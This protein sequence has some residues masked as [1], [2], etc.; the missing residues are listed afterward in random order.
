MN[1][2]IYRLLFN[3]VKGVWVVVGEIA[4]TRQKTGRRPLQQGQTVSL[5]A[6]LSPLRCALLFA[7]GHLVLSAPLWAD[8][9]ADPNAPASQQA[10]ILNTANG[11]P[12]VNIQTPT[13]GGVSRNQY[14]QFDVDAQGAILNN[15]RTNTTTQLGGL[16]SANPYL[17]GGSATVILNE[18]NSTNPSLLNGHIEVAGSR[19]DIIFANPAGISCSGCGFIN[20]NQTVLTTG[21]VIFNGNTIDAY[22]VN[23]G[24]ISINGDGLD[25][26]DSNFTHLISRSVEVNAGI[27][28][29]DLQITTG[30]NQV[31]ASNNSVTELGSGSG[32]PNFAIDVSALG[33]MYANVIRLVGTEDGVGVRNAG[34]IGASVGEFTL[35]VDGRLE[36]T[37]IIVSA[38]NVTLSA[39]NDIDNI[40]GEIHS[41]SGISITAENVLN[42]NGAITALSD[43]A[44]NTDGDLINQSGSILSNGHVTI[45]GNVTTDAQ[46]INNAEGLIQSQ[47]TMTLNAATINNTSSGTTAG[48][49]AGQALTLSADQI[50]NSQGYIESAAAVT[51]VSTGEVNNAQGVIEAAGDIDIRGASVAND[52]GY[53]GAVGNIAL[54]TTGDID[55]RQGEVITNKALTANATNIDNRE[56]SLRAQEDITLDVGAG[57]LQNDEGFIESN[58]AVDIVAATIT[59]TLTR[60]S[61][62][63]VDDD[64]NPIY[65]SDVDGNFILDED[66]DEQLQYVLTKGIVGDT[67]TIAADTVDNRDGQIVADITQVTADVSIDNS[68]GLIKADAGLNEITTH[69]LTQSETSEISGVDTQISVS[70]TFTNRGL[71]NSSGETR[72]DTETLLNYGTG[73]I[74]GDHIIIDAETLKNHK[75]GN[76]SA[77]IA[78]RTE[79]DIGV[80]TL[81]NRDGSTIYS[82]GDIDIGGD[83]DSDG[84]AE[85]TANSI[86]NASATI[87]ALKNLSIDADTLDN[88]DL[89]FEKESIRQPN[90]VVDSLTWREIW[91]EEKIRT[92]PS[93]LISGGDSTFTVDTL[94]SINSE[95]T[96]GGDLTHIGSTPNNKGTDGER[97]VTERHAGYSYQSCRRTWYGKKKCS[98]VVVT[99][100]Y[101]RTTS[102]TFTLLAP[103]FEGNNDKTNG[104]DIDDNAILNVSN[105]NAGAGGVGS[106]TRT[107]AGID[108]NTTSSL[109]SENASPDATYLV[110]TDAQF[111]DSRQWLS[112][113]YVTDQ[114]AKSPDVTNKR[115]GDG[116]YE[117]RVVRDQ[118][119]ALTGYRFLNNYSNDETQYRALLDNGITFAQAHNIRPGIRLSAEQMSQLTSDIVWL[120]EQE[121]TLANGGTQQVLVPKVYALVNDGDL[122]PSGS[123][124]SANNIDF[125][126]T[127]FSNGGSLFARNAI[128]VNAQDVQDIGGR[129]QASRVSVSADDDITLEG[130]QWQTSGDLILNAGRDIAVRSQQDETTQSDGAYYRY[131]TRKGRLTAGNGGTASQL[132]IAAG[133]NAAFSGVALEN[134]SSGDTTLQAGNK[135]V[136]DTIIETDRRSGRGMT[137]SSQN[138]VTSQIDAKGDINLL[139]GGDL[140]LRGAG[141]N[142]DQSLQLEGENINLTTAENKLNSHVH[143]GGYAFINRS[144]KNEG[145]RLNAGDNVTINAGDELNIYGATAAGGADITLSAENDISIQAAQDESY[146]YSRIKKKKSWGR[147][148]TTI[149]ESFATRNVGGDLTAGNN[150]TINSTI[151]NDNSVTANISTGDVTIVGSDLTAENQVAIAGDSVTIADKKEVM[152]TREETHKSGWGGLSKKSTGKIN[153]AELIQASELVANQRNLDLISASNIAII[154]SNIRSGEDINLT[155]VDDIVITADRALAQAQEW[156]KETKFLSSLSSVYSREDK[157]SGSTTAT[158]VASEINAGNNVT[159]NAGRARVVGSD[160]LAGN[161]VNVTTDIGDIVVE[162]AQ[163]TSDSYSNETTVKVSMTDII[164][165]A[166]D[167]DALADSFSDGQ[168]TMSIAKV[169]YDKIDTQTTATAHR[170]SQLL[171]NNNVSFDS[172]GDIAITGSDIIADADNSQQGDATLVAGGDVTIKETADISDTETDEVHGKGEISAVVQ[173]QAIEIVKAAKAV[174][175]AR[176]QVKTAKEDYRKYKKDLVLL[177]D[178]RDQLQTDYNNKV[179]GLLYEDIIDLNSLIDEVESD[180]EWYQA[181]IALAAINLASKITLLVQQ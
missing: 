82:D 59:N 42:T 74:Y 106:N 180:K 68:E 9:I 8:I 103:I 128:Q 49:L 55:N 100:P 127:N 176:D 167:V 107:L 43:I 177:N 134:N 50:D 102:S 118:I 135:L 112:S 162:S 175:E 11:L 173:H 2:G 48:I 65:L 70:D 67:V 171:A 84:Q 61:I 25:A 47:L 104:L 149:K 52:S 21:D 157:L 116:F 101:T 32:Q 113:S 56:G 129:L 22:R 35:S 26:T 144:L 124:I 80:T 137:Y 95:I 14:S 119:V 71:V 29:Q 53:I 164:E 45:D 36:N 96:A 12:Q 123:L 6:T 138:E 115:L 170:A 63:L 37:N 69:T 79:L 99:H 87:E 18:V 33:G 174:K 28:A 143:G 146:Q 23:D 5:T 169:T 76:K 114:L 39:T 89:Y 136:V 148:K 165:Q 78:A 161:D 125:T 139:A 140:L 20:A 44:I 159:I 27:W 64:G 130:S 158:V 93:R 19:A 126:N 117:Q 94:N 13:A 155:A 34:E 97:V 17:A 121:I 172:V 110:E 51:V 156:S 131:M 133:R 92:A 120:E 40:D 98:T 81:D 86:T 151:N 15:S 73:R 181:G 31:E 145:V 88:I 147:S 91:E 77:S 111:T 154:G 4:K 178:Q 66:G 54:T 109:F 3:V 150:L 108:V 179:P 83:I 30:T 168:A 152:F 75:E 10:I 153:R 7:L 166:I 62:V 105:Q 24:T 58:G 142:T 46:N 41:D 132:N 85:G 60:R 1:Q 38:G 72:V 57:T 90:E 16:V 141:I 160:I 122:L 163:S